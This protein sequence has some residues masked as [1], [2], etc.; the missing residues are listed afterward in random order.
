MRAVAKTLLIDRPAGTMT[1]FIDGDATQRVPIRHTRTLK[2]LGAIYKKLGFTVIDKKEKQ[3]MP[4][5]E[6]KIYEALINIETYG[7]TAR[8]HGSTVNALKRQNLVKGDSITPQGEQFM[9]EYTQR[10]APANPVGAV[11][12][13]PAASTGDTLDQTTTTTAAT[14]YT[15][16]ADAKPDISPIDALR[17]IRAKSLDA[18]KAICRQKAPE[19]LPHLETITLVDTTLNGNKS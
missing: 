15:A 7:N 10:T 18:V 17:I 13:L 2:H 4:F 1:V 8:L 9:M 5:T 11:R 12:E 16:I 19:A 6:Q 3:L 14:I